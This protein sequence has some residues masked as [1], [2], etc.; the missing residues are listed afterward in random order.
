MKIVKLLVFIFMTFGVYA[1]T[2]ELQ[3]HV[4][5]PGETAYGI[6]RQY[7]MT[8]EV[9]SELNPEAREVLRD[10]DRVMVH[11]PSA[12]VPIDSTRF[13]FHTVKP[14]ETMF[15]LSRQ[16]DVTYDILFETNPG[17]KESGLRVDEV[18]RI[19]KAPRRSP[20]SEALASDE[21]LDTTVD[22]TNYLIHEVQPGETIYALTKR[23]NITA[24]DLVSL[25]PI[26]SEGLKVEQRL[27]IKRLGS[28]VEN[29]APRGM[30]T[31]TTRQP[32]T[33]YRIKEG[34]TLSEILDIF[35]ITYDE[36]ERYNPRLQE[37]LRPGRMLL[38]PLSPSKDESVKRDTS[39]YSLDRV[40][41]KGKVVRIALF[42]PLDMERDETNRQADLKW[43]NNNEVSLSFYAGVKLALDSLL[44]KGIRSEV[45][46]YEDKAISK[47]VVAGMDSIDLIIG[48]IFHRELKPLQRA[49]A[50][51]NINVPMVSPMSRERA[52][53]DLPNV[54]QC[55]PG[56]EGEAVAIA[57]FINQNHP[58]RQVLLLHQND[59]PYSEKA[60]A[61]LN[62]LKD[63]NAVVFKGDVE[64]EALQAY[65]TNAQDTVSHIVVLLGSSRTYVA[66]A[67]NRLSSLRNETI[68]LFSESEL[69]K[70]P[71]VELSKL[72]R[73]Q[74]VRPENYHINTGHEGLANFM[75]AYQKTYNREANRFAMQGF[76]VTW[77][78]INKIVG[79]DIK[80]A[81]LQQF[82]KFEQTPSKS[83]ENTQRV[84]IG[85]DRK[86]NQRVIY[87]RL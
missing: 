85:L 36:L 15:R 8:V 37:G 10:G 21:P 84:W 38:I 13:H 3:Q 33:L 6:A 56:L 1:Q 19:P 79:E 43:V 31:D 75:L 70:M 42:L 57:H 17:L 54:Y 71:T 51:N 65:F 39:L 2:P 81:P 47:E 59:K 68:T 9:F 22:E 16:Y 18:I 74:L 60:S 67:I 44:S 69:V 50:K 63:T 53:L 20:I 30:A 24:G 40:Y 34:D 83:F 29:A 82:F 11:I 5:Q 35:D 28:P 86:L 78:F 27:K 55:L 4:V 52:I 23:Y 77:F 48:P 72:G 62:T 76:D 61:F 12:V 7:G 64:R 32:F 73:L 14:G 25:N 41:P 26:L 46:V 87:P 58:D 49:L 80:Q 45:W 66:S